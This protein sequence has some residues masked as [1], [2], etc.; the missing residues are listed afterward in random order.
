MVAAGAT[1]PPDPGSA[2]VVPAPQPPDATV[3]GQAPETPPEA[4]VPAETKGPIPFD[5]HEAILKNARTKTEQEVVQRFQ[6]QYGPHVELGS[7]IQQ[8][9]VG[10]VVQLVNELSSHPQYA[11]EVISALAR[12]L[13]ARR[14]MNTAVEEAP[15]ADLVTTDGK[16]EVYSAEQQAK[17][18]AWLLQKWEKQLEERLTPLQQREQQA[19]ERERY[20]VAV[21]DAHTRMAKVLEPFKALP[22][23]KENQQAIAAKTQAFMDEGHDPQTALGLAVANVLRDVVLPN[24]TAQSRNELVAQAVAKATGSTT[25]PGQNPAA[26]AK[27]PTSMTEAFSG[28]KF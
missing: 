4:A 8:D 17:R 10:T 19:Q 11:T 25:V 18:E 24:R 27:R 14:G 23:F 26:P 21:K 3:Q 20:E 12:T 1:T 15:Q 5:R 16:T 6:Q 28:I 13:G 2:P 7:R 9:P 22:E